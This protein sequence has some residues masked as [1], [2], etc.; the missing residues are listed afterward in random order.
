MRG[1]RLEEMSED[2]DKSVSK[3]SNLKIFDKSG[4]STKVK[5]TLNF[6]KLLYVF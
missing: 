3:L 4:T 2:G 6:L 5:H 1:M